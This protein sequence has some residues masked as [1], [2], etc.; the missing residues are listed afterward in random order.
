MKAFGAISAPN[1]VRAVEGNVMRRPPSRAKQSDPI[2]A[3]PGPGSGC[4]PARPLDR[5]GIIA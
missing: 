1:G 5:P 4:R 2:A 3:S